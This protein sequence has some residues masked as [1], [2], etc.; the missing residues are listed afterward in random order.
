MGHSLKRGCTGH[1][2]LR[3]TVRAP[4]HVLWTPGMDNLHPP[5]REGEWEYCPTKATVDGVCA[6]HVA[7]VKAHTRH[8]P[9]RILSVQGLPGTPATLALVLVFAMAE[10]CTPRD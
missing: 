6:G 7:D 1:L 10:V 8:V 9:F 3:G 5:P 4:S 2:R